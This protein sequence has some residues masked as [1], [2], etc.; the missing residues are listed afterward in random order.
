VGGHMATT[1]AYPRWADNLPRSPSP[2]PNPLYACKLR[3]LCWAPIP[4]MGFRNLGIWELRISL[5]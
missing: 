2:T 1:G 5:L 3:E 4:K